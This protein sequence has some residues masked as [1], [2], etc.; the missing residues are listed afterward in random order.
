MVKK[1]IDIMIRAGTLLLQRRGMH[2]FWQGKNICMKYTQ[3]F[4]NMRYVNN[5]IAQQELLNSEKTNMNS[6]FSFWL[7]REYTC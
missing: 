7:I 6:V 5:S 1:P 2:L 4:I 3:T